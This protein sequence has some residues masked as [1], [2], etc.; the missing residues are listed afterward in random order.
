MLGE[1]PQLVR[2]GDGL[3][4]DIDQ[5]PRE[6]VLEAIKNGKASMEE[7]QPGEYDVTPEH[8]R[9]E[10]RVKFNYNLIV[11]DN[12]TSILRL[13]PRYSNA[14]T[15]EIKDNNEITRRGGRIFNLPQDG[16]M[17]PIAGPKD[18]NPAHGVFI[19]SAVIS[20]GLLS[21]GQQV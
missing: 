6:I 1:Y 18:G 15:I 8:W 19:F 11:N 14:S 16:M 2:F 17:V 4:F 21:K 3:Q 5:D 9:R 13:I 12:G 7:L 10:I 20:G